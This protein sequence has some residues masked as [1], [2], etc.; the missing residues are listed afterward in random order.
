MRDIFSFGWIADLDR[1]IKLRGRRKAKQ[2]WLAGGCCASSTHWL[3]GFLDYGTSISIT[4]VF[5]SYI[6]V[7][8]H[9]YDE[10]HLYL[11]PSSMTGISDRREVCS[12]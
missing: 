12:I 8:L 7:R 9:I 1:V 2:S 10:T 6:R 4:M 11:R 5:Q 3:E